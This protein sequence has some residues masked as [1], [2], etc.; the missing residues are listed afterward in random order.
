MLLTFILT[1]EARAA[2]FEAVADH[3]SLLPLATSQAW[4]NPALSGLEYSTSISRLAAGYSNGGERR[5]WSGAADTYI[6]SGKSTITGHAAYANGTLADAG[7]IMSSDCSVVYPYLTYI[8]SPGDMHFEQYTFGGSWCGRLG[9]FFVGAKGGYDAKL[10]YRSADPRPRNVTGNLDI[11]VGGAYCIG[12]DNFVALHGAYSRYTQSS[13]IS[14]K[15]EM[16]E[17]T[18]YHL[19]GPGIFYNRFTGLGHTTSYGA[20]TFS[21]GATLYP[22][23]AC[24]YASAEVS[25]MRMSHILV[26]LN[27]LPMS[28]VDERS[29]AIEAGWRKK[30]LSIVGTWLVTQR[31]GYENIFGDATAGQYPLIA[32]LGMYRHI[33]LKSELKVAGQ[34]HA[35]SGVLSAVLAGGWMS[36]EESYRMPAINIIRRSALASLDVSAV[37]P[38]PGHLVVTARGFASKAFSKSVD[39]EDRAGAS[40]EFIVPIG[41][42]RYVGAAGG[43]ARLRSGDSFFAQAVFTF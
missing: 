20:S 36:S 8:D 24:V 31:H 30:A 40:A 16:G 19:V 17:S 35:G 15:S 3:A 34:C 38:L 23:N 7:G 39:M 32:T 2:D 26:D 14:F 29:A 12:S 33:L 13:D 27:K 41:H 4:S 43:Y 25:I 9:S 21:A 1:A 28:R 10:S 22:S 5:E 42:G 11:A 18:I 6:R 37:F